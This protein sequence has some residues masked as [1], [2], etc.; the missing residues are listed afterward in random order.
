ME[1]SSIG[2]AGRAG[3]FTIDYEQGIVNQHEEIFWMGKNTGVIQLEGTKTYRFRD[4]KWNGKKDCA[5]SIRDDK[6]LY[7]AILQEVKKLD[8]K[9]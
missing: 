8:D 6:E 3:V 7:E 9:K 4:R 5:L 1:Q 2:Q